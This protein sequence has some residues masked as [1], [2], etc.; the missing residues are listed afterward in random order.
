MG[1]AE[2][3]PEVLRQVQQVTAIWHV[4]VH[5]QL[6]TL[7]L[8]S[9]SDDPEVIDRPLRLPFSPNHDTSIGS[10]FLDMNDNE[11]DDDVLV[12]MNGFLE[13]SPPQG[14]RSCGET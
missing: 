7:P 14:R 5:N 4:S 11:G 3:N 9:I 13:H 12:L 8:S 10:N 6:R 2:L 1:G